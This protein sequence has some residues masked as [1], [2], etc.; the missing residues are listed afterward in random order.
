MKSTSSAHGTCVSSY[1]IDSNK[2]IV[3]GE[4]LVDVFDSG[5][6]AGGA[7]FNV[8]RTLAALGVEALFVSRLGAN[9]TMQADKWAQFLL[10][11]AQHYGLST[12]GLQLDPQRTTGT[13]R[14]E[15]HA[16][17][18]HFEIT[19]DVAWDYLDLPQAQNYLNA[20][21]G[22]SAPAF[23]YFGTLAQRQATSRATIAAVVRATR[24]YPHCIRYL[25]VNLRESADNQTIT[26]KSLEL[27]DWVKVNE[28]EL[29]QILA[30]FDVPAPGIGK[31]LE[32]SIAA[33]MRRFSLQ[34]LIVTRAEKGYASYG[35]SGQCEAQG[36][37]KTHPALVD[38]VGA[39]DAFSAVFLAACVHGIPLPQALSLANDCAFAVCG[40]R[41]PML[42]DKSAYAAWQTSP[43]RPAST[44]ASTPAL[45]EK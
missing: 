3:L 32:N 44:P 18:H 4:A 39:G 29:H 25:D 12:Q 40:T 13:V 37:G 30:W 38:T 15:Q 34:R 23:I 17:H 31:L 26:Q 35:E 28:E 8:A 2:V 16:D 11:N 24:Q 10:A 43:P 19:R 33:F 14:I 22:G 42:N 5:P 20:V 7:P 27:A 36:S 41:G 9:A 6:Q 45:S 1:S 21:L